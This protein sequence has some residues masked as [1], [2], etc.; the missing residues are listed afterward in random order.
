M[1][2]TRRVNGS[3]IRKSR[4]VLQM[5][6]EETKNG[7]SCVKKSQN[8]Q[9]CCP[10]ILPTK[11]LRS[12]RCDKEKTDSIHEKNTSSQ[13]ALEDATVALTCLREGQVVLDKKQD[14]K[15]KDMLAG[16]EREGECV[17]KMRKELNFNLELNID[18]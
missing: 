11:A 16:V 7:Q 14:T 12:S 3:T 8:K 9:K 10:K 1:Q 2:T 6:E 13:G 5:R 17:P 4:R 18:D 15:K